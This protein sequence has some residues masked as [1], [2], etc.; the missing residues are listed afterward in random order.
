MTCV[1]LGIIKYVRDRTERL[2]WWC[3][4]I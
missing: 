3:M 1:K 2:V 4:M